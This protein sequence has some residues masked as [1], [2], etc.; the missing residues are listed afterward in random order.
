MFQTDGD[1]GA[2]L[3]IERRGAFHLVGLYSFSVSECRSSSPRYTSAIY[4]R[5]QSYAAWMS[6]VLAIDAHNTRP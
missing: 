5:I 3:V 2:P 1:L 4:T 6:D